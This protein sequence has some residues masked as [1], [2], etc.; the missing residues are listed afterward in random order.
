MGG[1]YATNAAIGPASHLSRRTGR[2]P[3]LT[4]PDYSA[5]AS[6]KSFRLSRSPCNCRLAM[7]IASGSASLKKPLGSISNVTLT[8]VPPSIC[9]TVFEPVMGNGPDLL[10]KLYFRFA[11][12]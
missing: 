8:R 3:G 11:S 5:L 9:S 1:C 7:L 12:N 6:I 10:S 4:R 2:A